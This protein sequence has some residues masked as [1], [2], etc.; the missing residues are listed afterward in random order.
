MRIWDS[1]SKAKRPVEKCIRANNRIAH[2]QQTTH[3]VVTVY[4]PKCIGWLQIIPR[5]RGPGP[6]STCLFVHVLLRM[7]AIPMKFCKPMEKTT[8]SCPSRTQRLQTA[9]M[10]RFLFNLIVFFGVMLS[11]MLFLIKLA[12]HMLI[13]S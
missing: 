13:T 10:E 5:L 4:A 2:Q 8:A 12:K 7:V 1:Q 11:R 6:T 3:S 9:D